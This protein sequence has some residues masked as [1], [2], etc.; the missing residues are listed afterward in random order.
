MENTLGGGLTEADTAHLYHTASC[1][2]NHQGRHDVRYC[3]AILTN[4]TIRLFFQPELPAYASQL[5][6]SITDNL[7]WSEFSATYPS[8]STKLSW[9]VTK[10]KLVL[11]KKSHMPGDTIKGYLEV[12]FIEAS[13]GVNQKVFSKKYYYKGYFK[14]PLQNK[15]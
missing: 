4:D 8:Q 3:D 15:K 5:S 12:E 2:T 14:T 9:T 10:Q 1:W 13:S 6:I 11:D 7:F